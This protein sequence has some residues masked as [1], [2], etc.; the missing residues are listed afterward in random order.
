VG[1]SALR[2]STHVRVT[3]APLSAA[4][5]ARLVSR[6]GAGAIVLFQGITRE[7]AYLDYEAYLPMAEERME[8]IARA[9]LAA[10]SLQAVAVEHRVGRVALGEASVVVAVSAAH[11]REAFAGASE[12]IDTI[13]AEAPVWKREA[14]DGGGSHW[15]DGTAAPRSRAPQSSAAQSRAPQSG[16]PQSSAGRSSEPQS[17]VAQAR[18]QA[19]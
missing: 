10:H 13:K 9:C 2:E 3:R 4:A 15:V 16:A 7:V 6:P 5:L 8:S 1:S 17:P 11:R 12:M 18:R 14:R 19:R